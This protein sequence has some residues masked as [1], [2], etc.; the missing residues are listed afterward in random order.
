MIAG[1]VELPA[2]ERVVFGQPAEIAVVE[3]V[4]RDGARK[5][6]VISTRSLRHSQ[7]GILERV[8]RA[9]GAAHAG[10]WTRI[11][12]HTPVTDVVAAAASARA[13]HADVLV[14]IGGGSVVDATKAV[15]LALASRLEDVDAFTACINRTD[16]SDD[17]VLN[18][19]LRSIAVPT[20]LSA[21]EFTSIVGITDPRTNTKS[22]IR[23]RRLVPRSVVL[24]PAATLSTPVSLLLSTG[25]RAIDHAVETYCSPGAH[26]ASEHLSLH[27]L[28]LLGEALPRIKR[29][30]QDLEARLKAQLGMW[31]AVT[32][33]A[34]GV[35][36][37][38]SHGIGYVLG[39]VYGVPHGYTSCV[40][41]PAVLDWNAALNAARQRALS[42][43]LGAPDRAAFEIIAWLIEE[44][45][46][47][48]SLR[49][50]GIKR[51]DLD[52]IAERALGYEWVRT[53]PR[54][55]TRVEH[56]R[57]ILERAW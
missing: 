15:Q 29:A 55:I 45:G 31:Q 39:S 3:E 23:H 57:D 32:P 53:N 22:L 56:I 37:G 25:V 11:A 38:A 12:A 4:R 16:Q 21:A 43:A 44:L 2:L 13:A 36:V 27:G 6:F 30:P 51:A 10:T 50:V 48:R 18:H 41:L 40:M 9:L 52:D 5:V 19:G 28:Q 42:T 54:P 34:A 47:P 24:D 17:G 20:T 1:S 33:V 49:A 26:P 14:A 7:G 35:P 46:L 8:E